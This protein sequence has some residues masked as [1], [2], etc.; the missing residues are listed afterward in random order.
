[1]FKTLLSKGGAVVVAAIAVVA[2]MLSFFL[3]DGMFEHVD[4]GEIVVLQD[5]IDGELHVWSEPGLYPKY[6]GTITT[7]PV[8]EQVW[9]TDN[10]HSPT[11]LVTEPFST[12]FNDKGKGFISGS[13]RYDLPRDQTHMLNI[14]RNYRSAT[15]LH[16]ALMVPTIRNVVNQTGPV[17]SSMESVAERR[18]ELQQLIADQ[19]DN[20]VYQYKTRQEEVIDPLSKETVMRSITEIVIENGV[21][22]RRNSSP[23]SEFGI[24]TRNLALDDVDHEDKVKTQIAQQREMTMGIQT[25][26]ASALMAEQALLTAV[27]QGEA[28][29]KEAEWTQ[30]RLSATATTLAQQEADVAEIEATK[31][32]RVQDL[33][34]QAAALYKREQTLIGEGDGARK[35]AVMIADGALEQK[36]AAWVEAQKAWADAHSKRNVP[37]T[38]IGGGSGDGDTMSL[39]QL[40]S[41]QLARELSLNMSPK[42]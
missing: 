19:I 41:V 24:T 6:F 42:R 15:N 8:S 22:L 4:A 30:R 13:I 3:W 12:S 26:K 40:M 10:A 36:L 39:E 37:A 7:Y 20:G 1:M 14:H 35:R 34:T 9:F 11:D 32:L 33:A 17:M 16:M 28:N 27:K 23:L 5:P 29:A 38:V 21:A 25:A 31:V 18:S 2:I